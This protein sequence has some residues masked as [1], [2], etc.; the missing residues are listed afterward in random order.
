M[1]PQV[2]HPVSPSSPEQATVGRPVLD[3]ADAGAQTSIQ[4]EPTGHSLRF[5]APGSKVKIPYPVLQYSMA[6]FDAVLIIVASVVGGGLYQIIANGEFRNADQLLGGR[7]YRSCAVRFDRSI[8]RIYELH[9]AIAKRRL[10]VGRILAQWALVSLL[11]TL[12]A[13]LMKSGAFFSRGSILCFGPLALLL[14]LVCRRF[15]KRLVKAA[16]ADGQ[17]QGRRAIVLGTRDRTRCTRRGRVAG[18]VRFDRR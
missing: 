2:S 8:K 5:P 9:A 3:R 11:L 6:F 4:V 10:D 12:L 18:A 7:I 1:I 17:V 16:V 14:L 13:F 15:S